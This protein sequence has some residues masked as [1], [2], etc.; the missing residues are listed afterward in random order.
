[1]K[2]IRY[3]MRLL[4]VLLIGIIS[5]NVYIIMNTQN[6]ILETIEAIPDNTYETAIVLGAGVRGNE[7]TAILRDRIQ[8]SIN[9][10]KARKV[11]RIIMSGANEEPH[12]AQVRVMTTYAVEAGVP[13]EAIIADPN[14]Q[15]TKL[16]MREA[17]QTFHVNKA[18]IV[19]QK[20]HLYRA[21]YLADAYGIESI[22]Y[23]TDYSTY[24]Y[25]ILQN[26]REIL[27]RLKSIFVI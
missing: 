27:A 2:L 3:L 22:G 18:I 25:Q 19:T 10:Y 23:A 5:S 1:M 8:G 9:L 14:G 7:P 17:S 12:N 21:L 13:R 11:K 4:F 6:K 16:T 20:Y 15:R 24:K 26:G